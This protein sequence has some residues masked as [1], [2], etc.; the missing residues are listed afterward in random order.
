L[1]A[2]ACLKT[3]WRSMRWL[4][5]SGVPAFSRVGALSGK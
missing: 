3:F 1:L 4:L 2:S 5:A